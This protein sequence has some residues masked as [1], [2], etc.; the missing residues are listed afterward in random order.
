[1]IYFSQNIFERT[2]EDVVSVL[3]ELQCETLK[4]HNIS[5]RWEFI[6]PLD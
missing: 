2:G 4:L 6:F 5:L 1:M 3:T